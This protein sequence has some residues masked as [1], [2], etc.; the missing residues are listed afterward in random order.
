MSLSAK[1]VIAFDDDAGEMCSTPPGIVTD[2]AIAIVTPEETAPNTILTPSTFTSP[3][4]A[5]VPTC[6]LVPLSRCRAEIS[7][8]LTPPASFTSSN[9]RSI[10]FC[11]P[12]PRVERSPL[13]GKTVPTVVPS[14]T[15]SSNS[16]HEYPTNDATITVTT[17]DSHFDFFISSNLLASDCFCHQ[18]TIHASTADGKRTYISPNSPNRR[19]IDIITRQREDIRIV[20]LPIH[21]LPHP[22][23]AQHIT[24]RVEVD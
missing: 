5:S 12:G 16:P 9:A 19:Q 7:P 21:H 22:H 1:A 2:S 6:S 11:I 3:L 24:A 13:T 4:A 18:H 8:P 20:D 15:E 10:A 17:N 14:S 23:R